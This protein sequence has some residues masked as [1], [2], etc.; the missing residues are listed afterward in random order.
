MAADMVTRVYSNFRGCDFRGLEVNLLRSPDCLNVW[1][2]Y[3]ETESVRTRP[4]LEIKTAFEDAVYGIFFYGDKM[5]VHSGKTLYKVENGEISTLYEGL[6]EATSNSFI[7]ED[8]FYFKVV[9][10]LLRTFY[11]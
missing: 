4:K 10:C 7:Y 1:K 2:D 3:K 8:V 6:N 5:L 11:H 9:F